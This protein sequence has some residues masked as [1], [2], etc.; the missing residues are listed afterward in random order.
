MAERVENI[1]LG[2]RREKEEETTGDAGTPP[3]TPQHPPPWRRPMTRSMW[4]DRD[5]EGTTPGSP[6]NTGSKKGAH[7]LS[8]APELEGKLDSNVFGLR[9]GVAPEHSGGVKWNVFGAYSGVDPP[10]FSGVK[11]PGMRP[12]LAHRPL[13]QS[14]PM[15]SLPSLGA[16]AK[17]DTLRRPP[18]GLDLANHAPGSLWGAPGDREF[19]VGR[20]AVQPAAVATWVTGLGPSGSE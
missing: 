3:G 1:E 8:A 12:A 13:E 10:E 20:R 17:T 5:A 7:P 15:A 11:P 6:R 4:R 16:R 9:S 18:P 19:L 14:A 2:E